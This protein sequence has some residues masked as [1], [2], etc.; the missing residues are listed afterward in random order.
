MI[1]LLEKRKHNKIKMVYDKYT[2]HKNW[3]TT[4]LHNILKRNATTKKLQKLYFFKV[5]D[6][7]R[8]KMI[9][10]SQKFNNRTV[11]C[12]RNNNLPRES[13]YLFLLPLDH[14][15]PEIFELLKRAKEN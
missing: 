9:S 12:L 7:S 8:E 4:G 11:K 3:D 1:A 13:I 2:F 10:K 14:N 15:S 6:L 5:S